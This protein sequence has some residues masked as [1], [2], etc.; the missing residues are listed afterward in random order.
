[1]DKNYQEVEIYLRAYDFPKCDAFSKSDPFLVLYMKSG[2]S[3]QWVEIGRTETIKDNHHPVFEERFKV[4]YIFEQEQK[5]RID[6]YDEDANDSRNLDKHDYVGTSEFILG[7]VVHHPGGTMRKDL[8]ATRGRRE[9]QKPRNKKSKTYTTVEIKIEEILQCNHI[10]HLNLGASNLPKMDWFGSADPYL[11]F[12]R[13]GQDDS[14]SAM[15][16]VKVFSTEVLKRTKNPIWKPIRLGVEALCNGD[17]D[18]PLI[19]K[20]YDWNSNGTSD[21]IGEIQTS[22]N[23]LVKMQEQSLPLTRPKKL[24]KTYGTLDVRKSFLQ[25]RHTFIE[26]VRGGMDIRLLL[27]I[28]FTASNGNYLDY[29]TLHFLREETG[30]SQYM[31]ALSDVGRI[32]EVYSEKKEFACWGFGAKVGQEKVTSHCFPLTLTED[33]NV[34]GI[35]EVLNTYKSALA[36]NKL[37]FCGPTLFEHII[38]AA[39]NVAIRQTPEEQV[40]NLLLILT[41]GVISDMQKTK[42]AIVDASKIPLS[43]VIVGIGDADFKQ[44]EILDA[45]DTP[46]ESTA[47]IKMERDIVQFVPYSK[48]ARSPPGALSE[49]VLAELPEQVVEYY[50]KIKIL[51]N[52]PTKANL[53]GQGEFRAQ[54]T[55]LSDIDSPHVESAPVDVDIKRELPPGVEKKYDEDSGKNL[56]IDHVARETSWTIPGTKVPEASVHDNLKR[57]LPHGVEKKYD[58]DSGKHF[59][60]DHIAKETSWTIPKVDHI[61]KE[62]SWTTPELKVPEISV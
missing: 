61:A 42:N 29:G 44:M 15:L 62:T 53:Y 22:L 45:D 18:R 23:D 37:H 38:K 60:I 25:E 14:S 30:K 31:D 32:V 26:Y 9:G 36:S 10:L 59:Y 12:H 8:T 6:A 7:E 1:M 3:A 5:I 39:T 4:N 51:P 40:Y 17:F 21:L 58:K 46:L 27:A 2:Y 55:M 20:C 52:K 28:D 57:E 41:D 48:F 43:V 47:G 13:M 11:E 16:T 50:T 35:D 56:Y 19:I 54:T 33:P 49:C 34:K 24:G